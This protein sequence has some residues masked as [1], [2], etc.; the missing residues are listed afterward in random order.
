LVSSYLVM[1]YL[2]RPWKLIGLIFFRTERNTTIK[3]FEIQSLRPKVIIK[4][5]YGR[6]LSVFIMFVPVP[7]RPFK[8]SLMFVGKDRSLAYSGEQ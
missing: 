7:G 3:R 5:F 8:P 6:N 1:L 2:Y 4:P